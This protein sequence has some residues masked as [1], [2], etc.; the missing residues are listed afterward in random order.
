MNDELGLGTISAQP[1]FPKKKHKKN[2]VL[3]TTVLV[4]LLLIGLVIAF[5]LLTPVFHIR[6]ITVTG[7]GYLTAEQVTEAAELEVGNNIFTF[8]T[9]KKEEKIAS[10]P[11][12]NTVN[13][14]RELPDQVFINITECKPMAEILCGESLYL[15]VDKTGKILDSTN[16]WQKYGVPV[17]E[18]IGVTQFEVGKAIETE[19][20]YAVASMLK[21]AEELTKNEMTEQLE[22][23][24]LKDEKIYLHFQ[25]GCIAE[26]GSDPN[27][28]RQIVY[29]KES[30]RHL[31]EGQTGLLTFTNNGEVSFSPF[32][33]ITE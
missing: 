19:S 27:Y 26:I 7:N 20:P 18:G 30:L 5:G 16:D 24:A 32:P 10:L 15:V 4:T 25:N 12:V 17:M 31:S 28:A 8:R 2:K 33:D 13:I 29:F 14:T 3:K 1:R 6:N 11:F 23:I 21:I 22:K 9:S